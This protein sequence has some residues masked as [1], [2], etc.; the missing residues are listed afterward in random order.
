[1]R[2]V[3]MGTGPFAVPSFDALLKAGHEI[4]LVVT[5]PQPP[6]KSRKG[7]PPSPVRTWAEENGLPIFDPK[8]I[9]EPDA[10]V[11][12]HETD[13]ELMVVCDLSL[14]HI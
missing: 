10:V 2:L 14:I 7:P 9:N 11:R 12:V 3:L 4:L 8:S 1:M 6:V 5:K 13:A